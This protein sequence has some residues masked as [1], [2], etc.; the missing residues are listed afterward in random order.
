M[1][2][3][4]VAARD[5]IHLESD[6]LDDDEVGQRFSQALIERQRAGV[7]VLLHDSV[8]TMVSANS[9]TAR[10]AHCTSATGCAPK[11]ARSSAA[12]LG[13]RGL[14]VRWRTD[15]TPGG[16]YNAAMHIPGLSRSFALVGPPASLAPPEN[17]SS[18]DPEHPA[19]ET[20]PT[21]E[22][23]PHWQDVLEA[24]TA[25][26]R[27]IGSTA[28]GT[29][30]QAAGG[31]LECAEALRQLHA[32]LANEDGRRRDLELKLFDAS[33]ALAQAQ[34]ALAGLRD[35]E[36]RARHEAQHDALTA[37]PNRQHFRERLQQAL[38][39]PA[40]QRTTLAVLYIDL[41]DFKPVNDRHG[42][43]TGDELL[44]IVATRLTRAVRAEDMVSR[45]GGDEFAC[46]IADVTDP[47]G[48]DALAR[49]LIA[50]V[51]AP[52]ALGTLKLRVR[53]SIG[54]AVSPLDASDADALLRRA[55]AAMYHAKRTQTGA[56]RFELLTDDPNRVS[57]PSE[58]A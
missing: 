19:A 20:G 50:I 32:T 15:S 57:F 44:R 39:V 42:H 49:K 23:L 43:A 36:R 53:P 37:L 10:S 54:I 27:Q 48:L 2:V 8:G 30:A 45:L 24:V 3:A 33:M 7:A 1:L 35:G 9:A 28:S 26:L 16:V 38:A 21:G 47:A 58:P 31:L 29:Q 52:V 5:H 34:S 12:D 25:R 56:A 41:D 14:W 46:L 11:A 17:E 22:T 13:R 18:R 40:R 51:S 6:I 4:L 55:D